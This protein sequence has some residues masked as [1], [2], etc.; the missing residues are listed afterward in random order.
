M[1]WLWLAI[2][3]SPSHS[4]TPP[5]NRTEGENNMKR[6]WLHSRYQRR[7]NILS[8]CRHFSRLGNIRLNWKDR[9]SIHRITILQLNIEIETPTWDR[10]VS[11]AFL[12]LF[13]WWSWFFKNVIVSNFKKQNF[14]FSS[15]QYT[16]I[17]SN[18][19]VIIFHVIFQ[20]IRLAKICKKSIFVH[21]SCFGGSHH[22]K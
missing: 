12:Y 7:A 9:S 6:S 14:F 3:H 4:L 1:D 16:A 10:K 15:I 18:S 17:V 22:I 20:A 21:I 2:R 11:I 19:R 5:L 8:L 13:C